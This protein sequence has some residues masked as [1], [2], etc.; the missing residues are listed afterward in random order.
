MFSGKHPF[1]SGGELL[2]RFD[3]PEEQR[4]D[5]QT[6]FDAGVKFKLQSRHLEISVYVIPT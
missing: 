4:K 1:F 5:R 3:S 6:V 2:E